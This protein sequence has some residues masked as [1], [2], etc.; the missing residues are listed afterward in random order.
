ML[1]LKTDKGR[2]EPIVWSALLV[3]FVIL[4]SSP[5]FAQDG[6][7]R[8]G[9]DPFNPP[10][11][12]DETKK[13]I[14]LIKKEHDRR[15]SEISGKIE[16]VKRRIVESEDTDERERL[17]G[18]LTSLED[19]RLK[20]ATNAIQKVADLRVKDA[21]MKLASLVNES[22]EEH[23]TKFINPSRLLASKGL[24]DVFGAEPEFGGYIRTRFAADLQK[25]ND[26]EDLFEAHPKAYVKLKYPIGDKLSFFI[27]AYGKLD[28]YTGGSTRYDHEVELDEA[29]LDIFFDKFDIR[30][31][32]QIF[33]WGKTDSINPT[34]NLNAM[35]LNNVITGDIGDEI[36]PTFAVKLD[37]YMNNT[38][39]ELI[40]VPF[41]QENRFDLIGSDWAILRHG[42]FTNIVGGYFPYASL[43][44]DE[45]QKI[46]N[47]LTLSLY[48]P[49][50][51]TDS[52][53]NTQGGL[54]ISSTYKGF[55][56]SL[57]YIYA[58]DK[59][60]T[61]HISDDL[62]DAIENGT[63]QGYIAG[64]SP[65]EI[66]GIMELKYNRY[67]MAGFDFASN[68]GKYGL[69]GEA[70]LF[71]NRYTYTENF[72]AIKRDYLLYAFGIDRQF[73]GNFYVNLQLVQKI[74]FNYDHEILEDEVLSAMTLFT[75]KKFFNEKLNL[76][77]RVLYNLN[78]GDVFITPKASYKYTDNLE[79]TIGM[80]ILEGDDYTIFGYF[81]NNNQLF[82]EIKYYF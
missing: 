22:P 61:L 50:Q 53:E 43:L 46:L 36:I 79:F 51:P 4:L 71:F 63:V 3:F 52:P 6:I 37:Y 29:Y 57:S 58:F 72:E 70:A 82:F 68:I 33:G 49:I 28:Y 15:L 11:H 26:F 18:L 17:M 39:F 67:H 75:Y 25:D 8:E 1:A 44:D 41:F 77:M 5:I 73:K 2:V 81:S 54:R 74:I 66:P 31:G 47:K 34:D 80:N 64:L 21:Q 7:L 20:I 14:N 13:E 30:I 65:G 32:N 78:D 42:L 27:S 9:P 40:V 10:V 62:I 76:E 24:F 55:D 23:Y 35:Y 45:T 12:F 60:P 19:E 48:S 16:R 59:F 69:R 38:T 56:F